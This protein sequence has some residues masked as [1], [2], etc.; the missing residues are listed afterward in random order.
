MGLRLISHRCEIALIESD[1]VILVILRGQ[2]QEPVRSRQRLADGHAVRPILVPAD[3]EEPGEGDMRHGIAGALVPP[4][5]GCAL[6]QSHE[7]FVAVGRH[8]RAP[9]R[10][11]PERLVRRAA[12]VAG[13]DHAG[14]RAAEGVPAERVEWVGRQ[15]PVQLRPHLRASLPEAL[16]QYPHA[17]IPARPRVKVPEP[18]GE[19]V[20]AGSRRAREADHELVSERAEVQAHAPRIS[21]VGVRIVVDFGADAR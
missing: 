10:D 9:E 1:V 15:T 7:P 8:A 18:C 6:D 11:E 12:R 19:A 5:L 3:A 14:E 16:M 2:R 20:R 4:G 13:R 21:D 17:V